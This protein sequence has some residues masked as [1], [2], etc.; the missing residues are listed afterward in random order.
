VRD[1]GFDML[2]DIRFRL[3][4]LFRR[5]AV[6]N[7]LSEELRFHFNRQV[8][9]FQESGMSH[10]EARRRARLELGGAEQI[11]EEY[12]DL[13]GVRFLEILLQDIHYALRIMRKSPGFVMVAV[14]TL[15]LG[16]GANTAIFS[17]VNSVLLN[18]LPY[19]HPEQIVTLHESKPNFRYGAISYLNFRDWQRD[20]HTFSAM[21][22]ERG[23]NY[24]YSGNGPTERVRGGLVSSD[25]FS[26]LGV[27]PMI[28][29]LF[30]PDEDEPSASPVVLLGAGFWSQRFGS[31]T[32]V[33]GQSITLDGKGYRVV[34][35]IPA[36]FDLKLPNM[37]AP[38]DVYVP[39]G[40]WD[41]PFLLKRSAPLGIHGIGRLKPGVT[42]SQAQ[43]DMDSVARNLA[44]AYPVDDDG[45]GASMVPLTKTI[46]G[47]IK[48][49]LLVLLCAV[50][51]V[52]LI[53]CVN[54]A[55]LL[56]ARSMS[57]A[58]EF[59]VRAALGASKARIMRQLLTESVLLAAVGGG[60]GLLI[61][62][63]G[64]SAGLSVVPAA[65]PRAGEI[66][67]DTHVL[68][69]TMAISF[70]AGIVF[71]L[72]PALK[73]SQLNLPGVLKESGRGPGAVRHRTQ[74]L[75]VVAEMALALVLLIGAGLMIRSLVA[76]WNVNP[77]FNPSNVVTF[78]LGLPSSFLNASADAI[79]ADLRQIDREIQSVHG[80]QAVSLSYGA[81]PLS[82]DDEALFWME[83]QPK[84]K[85]DNEMNWALRYI[86]E[87]EYLR[88]MGIPL[89]RGRFITPQDDEHAP[90]IVV[91]DEVFARKFFGNQDPIGKRIN[92]LGPNK[93]AEIVGVVGHVK[94]WGLA[95]DDNNLLRAQVYEPY[96]QLGDEDMK[97]VPPGTTAIVRYSGAGTGIFDT[98]RHDL[99][100]M[101]RGNVIWG[102]Q[103]MDDVVAQ[104]LATRRFSM[105]LL[106]FFAALALVLSS[107]GIY[108]VISYLSG[109]RT[110]EIGIR[111][112]L[113]AEPSAVLRL[114]LSEGVKMALIG[115]AI[116]LAAAIGLTRLMSSLLYGVSATDPLTFIGV[117]VLL[118]LVA[119]AAC[120]IP[121]RRAMRVDPIVALR[122]E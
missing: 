1:G 35:V 117:A 82:G 77:G 119:L 75:F 88:A 40:Q 59:A 7:D 57:R 111:M 103:S 9:K 26:I 18:P 115:V 121:A 110:Q 93:P 14:L 27:R 39:I 100:R 22:I 56:L 2:S 63:W 52:L 34:G 31:S 69:F 10:G 97:L 30:A 102:A 28:G 71:G 122:Y 84:P 49:F 85:A 47:N 95:S 118:T 114:V 64:I 65:L 12:R 67:L 108:G 5:D 81:F 54:V 78:G 37:Q 83:G 94:Q 23:K 116:G 33:L 72:A 25:F 86:V 76:L 48:P 113:G 120:Y 17:V 19:P 89:E 43:A 20:N 74:R 41:N 66:R 42:M 32:T 44:A 112:A 106:G 98:I 96:M 73:V 16:I 62:Q 68:L 58:R 90:L 55:N 105:I 45:I 4:S 29:R 80:V 60:L 38:E 99:Q 91:V 109:Q 61:A 24:N 13:S 11:K 53:A 79:R 50:G 8:E 15:A 87:P 70:V 92:L 104:S 51:F 107:I 6:E 101:N 36:N 46:T 21:A 3:R